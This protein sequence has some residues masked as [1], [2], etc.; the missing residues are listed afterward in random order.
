[1]GEV[2]MLKAIG[3]GAAVF[4]ILALVAV[5]GTD[6][7]WLINYAITVGIGCLVLVFV[8]GGGGIPAGI[9]P[10]THMQGHDTKEDRRRRNRWSIYLFL[11]ALPNLL[12]AIS[13][14]LYLH[15]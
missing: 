2:Y 3:S 6:A 15:R 10:G 4:L 8:F 11:A 5:L 7:E 12:G 14:Y 9:A 1:M 13:V